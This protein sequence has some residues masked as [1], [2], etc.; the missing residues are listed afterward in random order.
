MT[1]LLVPSS[2]LACSCRQDDYM[3]CIPTNPGV[4]GWQCSPWLRCSS[5]QYQPSSTASCAQ[6]LRHCQ[7]PWGWNEMHRH[8]ATAASHLARGSVGPVDRVPPVASRHS[9][10]G[11][12]GQDDSP[13]DGS[14]YLLGALDMPIV[15]PDGDE[16]L[17]P[18]PL[19]SAGL[20]LHGHNLQNLVLERCPKKNSVISDFLI[21]KEQSPPET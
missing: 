21:G 10:N 3:D 6:R 9:D 4:L 15:V 18:G 7:C 12:L 19:A 8:R 17:E 13:T 16:C 1:Q 20:L 11:E 5:R 14:G 2:L